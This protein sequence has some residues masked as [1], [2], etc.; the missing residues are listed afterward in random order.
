MQSG[1]GDVLDRDALLVSLSRDGV[2]WDPTVSGEGRLVVS[3]EF[4]EIANYRSEQDTRIHID[5]DTYNVRRSTPYQLPHSLDLV[6]TK[7]PHNLSIQPTGLLRDRIFSLEMY[8]YTG[9]SIPD[10]RW[11]IHTDVSRGCTMSDDWDSAVW[12]P[13]SVTEIVSDQV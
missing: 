13:V 10:I 6:D 3:G 1:T 12:R 11:Y 5:A 4:V 8:G 2:S 7:I 9:L